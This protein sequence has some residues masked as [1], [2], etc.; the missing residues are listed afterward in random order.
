M[1]LF[2]MG[3]RGSSSGSATTGGG[4]SSRA[5]PAEQKTINTAS[6]PEKLPDGR[7]KGVEYLNDPL[8]RSPGHGEYTPLV[9]PSGLN[10]MG[11]D[12]KASGMKAPIANQSS[13]QRAAVAKKM[14]QMNPG[15]RA[16][17]L[18]DSTAAYLKHKTGQ[19]PSDTA[20]ERQL[21]VWGLSGR[22]SIRYHPKE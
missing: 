17:I 14:N 8:P 20:V 5:I 2:K 9:S 12:M 18:R 4:G 16:E 10:K 22:E 19:A 21:N 3:G 1:E 6:E 15:K 13:E 7:V 11:E